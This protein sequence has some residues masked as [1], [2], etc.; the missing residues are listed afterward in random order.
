MSNS[1]KGLYHLTQGDKDIFALA[2]RENNPN[3]ITNYYL[4][5]ENSGTW[6]RH[7]PDEHVTRLTVPE[8]RAATIKWQ[9]GYN[10][11]FAVWQHFGEPEFFGPRADGVEEWT[12]LTTEAY[13]ERRENVDRVY[14][15]TWDDGAYPIFHH[16]HGPLFLPWQLAVHRDNTAVQIIPGGMGCIAPDTRIY[17]AELNQH[18][19]VAELKRMNRAPVVLAWN[20]NKFAKQKATVPWIKGKAALYKVTMASGAQITV[21]EEHRFLA[22][23]GWMTLK[24]LRAFPYAPVLQ[25][26]TN[27]LTVRADFIQRVELAVCVKSGKTTW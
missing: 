14:K 13:A 26:V 18:I 17:D 10:D 16:S 15:T 8:S 25:S 11:L 1:T 7:V 19:P 27:S 2:R 3:V 20:G 12:A 9:K 23:R 6:W 4:R 5:S 21:T 24:A 22:P